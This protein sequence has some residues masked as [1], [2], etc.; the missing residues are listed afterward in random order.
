MLQHEEGEESD[1][2][3]YIEDAI[4]IS[5]LKTMLYIET[6]FVYLLVNELRLVAILVRNVK[7]VG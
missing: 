2:S 1:I 7:L 6:L 4:A 3:A 5:Q